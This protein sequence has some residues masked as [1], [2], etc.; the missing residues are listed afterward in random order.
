LWL[1]LLGRYWRSLPA[2]L[3]SYGEPAGYRPLREA[4]ADYLRTARGVRCAADQVIIVAS[5]QR[6]IELVAQVLLD[7]GAPVWI[8]D[9]CYFGAGG[10]VLCGGGRLVPVP[11]DSEGLDVATGNTR[12]KEA[13]MVYVTP[14]FQDPLGVT[15]S[16][17][18]R[19]NLLEW[20]ARSGAWGL[21]DDYDSDF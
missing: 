13:R 3:M 10:A 15:M 12:S 1:R 6:A 19:L 18:R 5:S 9:P 7:P 17:P 21:E 14:S 16:L 20:A 11:I 2:E 4:I 8:E